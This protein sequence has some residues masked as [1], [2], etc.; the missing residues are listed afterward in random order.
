MVPGRGVGV[1]R[2]S[3]LVEEPVLDA[4]LVLRGDGDVVRAEQEHL[5][6][7]PLDAPVQPE[8]QPRG[9]VDQALGVGVVHLGQVH[10]HRRARAEGLADRACLVVGARVQRGDLVP[11]PAG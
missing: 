8:G 9:E 11:D 6:G 3:G 1:R 10:D 5:R 2:S 4:R 7:D